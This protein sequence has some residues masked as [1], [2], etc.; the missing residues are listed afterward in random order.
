MLS[1]VIDL[2][3]ISQ[4]A[5]PEI[6]Y[7][8]FARLNRGSIKLTQAELRNAIY[9]SNITDEV[10]EEVKKIEEFGTFATAFSPAEKK[11]FKNINRVFQSLA[12]IEQFRNEN[13]VVYFEKYNSR[14]KDMINTVLQK[15]QNNTAE[16]KITNKDIPK[17]VKTVYLLKEL[18]NKSDVIK[19]A[20]EEKGLSK[21]TEYTLDALMPFY[22]V[23][24]ESNIDDI[25]N[26]LYSCQD[27][28]NTFEKSLST[29]T[30]VN[31]RVGV[32]N[33]VISKL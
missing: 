10:R 9:A 22:K 19:K 23:I 33:D 1:S 27:F 3:V 5:H 25:I 7:D 12:Y 30:N 15:Y 2:Y 6:K 16:L 4:N 11:R 17:V 24:S 28:L 21:S 18:L 13:G 32:V 26:K 20:E 31:A 14:P 8:V 29:T